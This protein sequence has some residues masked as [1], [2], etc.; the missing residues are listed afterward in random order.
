GVFSWLFT[1]LCYDPIYSWQGYSQEM[2]VNASMMFRWSTFGW[3]LLFC[4]VL[5]LLSAGIPAWRASRVN[6]VEA[7]N[8]DTK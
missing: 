6:P 1:S 7:M 3:T 2:S 5:N 4:F 8:G